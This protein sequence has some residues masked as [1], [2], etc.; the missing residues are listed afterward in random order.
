M[1]IMGLGIMLPNEIGGVVIGALPTRPRTCTS[2]VR[3]QVSNPP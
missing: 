2:S 1:A 3:G